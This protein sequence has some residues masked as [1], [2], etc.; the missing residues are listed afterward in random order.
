MC[1]FYISALAGFLSFVD[2]RTS[3]FYNSALNSVPYGLPL[4]KMHQL[5][6]SHH[7]SSEDLNLVQD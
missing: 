7:H 2:G 4:R 3:A 1:L 6:V 5:K